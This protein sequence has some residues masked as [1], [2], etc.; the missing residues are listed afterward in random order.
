MSYLYDLQ[1]L[2][3]SVTEEMMDGTHENEEMKEGDG[4]DP[5]EPMDSR[6]ENGSSRKYWNT[7]APRR[8]N[9]RSARRVSPSFGK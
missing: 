4:L 8:T 5:S 3:Q 2:L 9:L 7:G 6:Q 1:E